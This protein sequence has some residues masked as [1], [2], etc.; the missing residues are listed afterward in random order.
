MN[1][2]KLIN[3]A[4]PASTTQNQPESNP[5]SPVNS[6][7]TQSNPSTPSAQSTPSTQSTIA[8]QVNTIQHK[9]TQS[10]PSTRCQHRPPSQH[11]K[12]QQNSANPVKPVNA[13]NGIHPSKPANIAH[14]LDHLDPHLPSRY[15]VR[16]LNTNRNRSWQ[17]IGVPAGNMSQIIHIRN[18]SAL[19]SRSTSRS[20]N[21]WISTTNHFAT[22]PTARGKTSGLYSVCVY[23][24]P[25]T[26]LSHPTQADASQPSRHTQPS[27]LLTSSTQSSHSHTS[28][29]TVS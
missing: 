3:I 25:M 27:Q 18:T 7:N 4:N 10:T 13:V 20:G 1:P 8:T 29:P 16:D 11:N 24:S 17:I 2:I 22:T 26:G 6:V 23:A 15:V 12:T 21:L 5:L 19:P 28:Q 14:D 9:S